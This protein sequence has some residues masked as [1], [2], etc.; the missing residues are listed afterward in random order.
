MY[1]NAIVWVVFPP[2][3]RPTTREPLPIQARA[4]SWSM[5]TN[6]ALQQL[7]NKMS[8]GDVG[9]NTIRRH[10]AVFFGRAQGLGV[11]TKKMSG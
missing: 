1:D 6:A 4:H 5:S 2:R 10:T 11:F 3:V 9:T 7:K 8:Y